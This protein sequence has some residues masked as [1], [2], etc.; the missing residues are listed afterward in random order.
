[1]SG[2]CLCGDPGCPRCF[3]QPAF[4]PPQEVIDAAEGLLDAATARHGNHDETFTE[5]LM[6][7]EWEGHAESCPIPKLK[8]WM[9]T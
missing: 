1:M 8:E 2:P 9:G 5:C 4:E 3:P 7:G 6:C